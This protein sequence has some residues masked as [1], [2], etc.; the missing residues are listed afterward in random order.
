MW[1]RFQPIH[2]DIDCN[3]QFGSNQASLVSSLCILG[4]CV[5]IEVCVEEGAKE[6]DDGFNED[7]RLICNELRCIDKVIDYIKA[8]NQSMSP[9][10]LSHID[11][12]L[13]L[14][15]FDKF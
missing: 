3:G 13:K 8:G 15:G 7:Q 9:A 4:T 5:V 14:E 6:M 12:S 1:M 2:V 11:I 10:F